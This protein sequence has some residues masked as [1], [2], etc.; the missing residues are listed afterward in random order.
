MKFK[1]IFYFLIFFFWSI[2]S[3]AS[4]KENIIDNLDSTDTLFF[5]FTQK[6]DNK[7][8]EGTCQVSYPAKIF[9]EYKDKYNKIIISDG[10]YLVVK[11]KSI[12]QVYKY[13]LKKTPFK[14]ILDKEFLIEK[15]KF[16]EIKILD[17]NVSS[18][19]LKENNLD[20]EIFFN[21]INFNIIGWNT[22][23]VYQNVV[24][25]KIFN[26]KKNITISNKIFR[27]N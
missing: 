26:L 14:I 6:I 11:N 5:N 9:C 25:F 10:K 22:I 13:E 20:F 15:I 21:S 23:D 12:D 27:I 2:K 19:L 1:L 24:N 7:I 16:S 18:I 3:Y 4:L 17:K 8:N